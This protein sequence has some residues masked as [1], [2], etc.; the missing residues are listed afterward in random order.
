MRSKIELSD[1]RL[2]REHPTQRIHRALSV[3]LLRQGLLIRRIL[4][5]RQTQPTRLEHLT[6]QI[7][8]EHQIQRTLRGRQTRRIR[9]G[10]QIQPT[11]LELHIR[12]ILHELIVQLSTD[13]GLHGRH[14]HVDQRGSGPNGQLEHHG[15]RGLVD[16]RERASRL[17]TRMSAMR[18]REIQPLSAATLT[19]QR[20]PA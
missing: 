12:R 7:L 9:Q 5:V 1:Q 16:Q 18:S 15:Q 4:R 11:R 19:I 2:R 17:C 20:L 6:Q 8:R 3:Q 13:R 10:R 14:V